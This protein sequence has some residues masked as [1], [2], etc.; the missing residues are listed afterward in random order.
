MVIDPYDSQKLFAVW[1]VDRSQSPCPSDNGRR[2][3]GLLRQWRDDLDVSVKR[4]PPAARPGHDQASP[5]DYTQVTDPSVAFDGSGQCLRSDLCKPAVPAADGALYLTEF[6][7]SGSH[8]EPRY[9]SRTTALSTSGLTGSDAATSP[10]WPSMPSNH[11]TG[12]PDPYAN[13]V[14][15][16]WAS[17]DTEPANPES[18]I[19]GRAS[20]PTGP[21]WSSGRR[22]PV[23]RR[24]RRIAGFQRRDDRQRERQL[25]PAGRFAPATGDQPE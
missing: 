13:N 15:I 22:F 3:G 25:R 24:E 18:A 2:R 16:A 9:R 1:G 20:T 23:R 5:T 21:S 6:N 19:P 10:V 7:F 8:A 4:S 12:V 14:Y 17:I 11:P